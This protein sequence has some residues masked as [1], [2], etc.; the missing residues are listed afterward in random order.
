MNLSTAQPS[1]QLTQI[2]E[3]YNQGYYLQAWR[4]ATT[5]A[6]L[7][8][9]D[10]TDALLLAG[11]MANNLGASRL[12][13][14][15]HLKAYR[16]D[17]TNGEAAYYK[18]RV[19]FDRRGPLAAWQFLRK[20][21]E[22]IDAAP[23][24]QADWLAYH[25]VVLGILR[26]FD[27]AEEWLAKA[28]K[29][30]PTNPWVWI[31]RSHLFELEDKYEASLCA[32]QRSLELRPDFRPGV[33]AV[34]SALVLLGRDA[35]ALALLKEAATKVESCWL[36][37]QLAQ[38]Q[39]EL[40]Q[41]EDA[42]QSFE[43]FAELAPLLDESTAKWLHA[44]RADVAYLC[45]D[46]EA[47]LTLAKL[48]ES[49]FHKI[50]TERMEAADI[51]A[52]RVVLPVGFV[53]QHHVTC[54]PATLT[55]LSQYWQMPADHLSV[56]EAICYDGTPARSE[57]DWA[58]KQGWFVREFCVTWENTVKL[59][60]RGV[61]FTLTTVETGSAHL[62]S[63]IG[64]DSRRGTIL[65]RDPYNRELG[66]FA[67]Q[68][69]LE[70]YRSSGPRGMAMVPL[71]R[72]ELL[73][74]LELQDAELYDE[75]Y[76]VQ[77][78]L[79]A[80]NRE[81]AVELVKAMARHSETH[82]LTYKAELSV[83]E[84]DADEVRVLACLDKL[85]E[86]FPTDGNWRLHKLSVLRRL[87]RRNDRV[88]MLQEICADK[89]SHP[90]FWQM[91]A[92]ELSDDGREES[93][94][95]KLL[96]RAMRLGSTDAH[97]YYL[98]ANLLWSQRRFAEAKELYRFAAC[99]K[100]TDDYYVR[101][102]FSAAQYF[103]EQAEAIR[104]LRSRFQRFGKQSGYPARTLSWGYEQSGQ[105][106]KA[107]EA[108]KEGLAL[109]PDDAELI[110][111]AAD[112]FA[113][114]GDFDAA[115]KWMQQAQTKARRLDWL[116]E[117]AAIAAYR[118]DVKASLALWQQV[119]E[120]E[121]LNFIATRNLAQAL[122]D[123]NG[124]AA[125]L[126]FLRA[127]VAQFPHNL[128]LHRLLVEWLRETPSEAEQALRAMIE[129]DPVDAWARR[130]LALTLAQQQRY[131]TALTEAYL[132]QKLE[133]NQPGAYIVLGKVYADAGRLEE[134]KTAYRHALKLSVDSDYALANLMA[135]SHSST[136]RRAVLQFVKEELMQQ[137]TFGDGLLAYREQAGGT[138][139]AEELR[140]LL[141]SALQARP[142]LWHA[143][144]ALILQLVDMQQYDEAFT[145]AKQATEFFPLA[146]RIWFDLSLVHQGR[147]DRQG[148]IAAL[149]QALQISPGWGKAVRQLA[150]ALMNSGQLEQAQTTLEQ[151]IAQAPLEATTYGYLADVLWRL[152]EK[153]Q[154][155]ER[156][157]HALTLYPGYDWGWGC[158]RHWS[159][160]LNRFDD[161]IAFVR[162]NAE[163]RPAEARAW[164][165]IAE[166]LSQ[167][168]DLSER[169]RALEQANAIQPHLI[170][171][172]VLRARLLAEAQR[173]DEAR[174]ACAPAT[175]N[176]DL[177]LRL[178]NAAALV[179]AESGNLE[180]ALQQM[181]ALVAEEPNNY[182]GWS[183]LADWTRS[184]ET[185]KKDYLEAAT[186]LVRISPH[187]VVSLGYLGEARNL[188][189]DRNGAKEA[190]KRA[191]TLEPDYD[192][193]GF[194]LFDL[195]LED[196]EFAAAQATLALLQQHVGSDWVTLRALELA[197]KQKDAELALQ[198]F[199]AL[200][201]A[202]G[203]KRNLLDFALKALDEADLSQ[204]ADATL[205]RALEL[206]NSISVV[207]EVYADR[208]V[209]RGDWK[210][211]RDRLESVAQKGIVW[212]KASTQF[213]VK[214]IDLKRSSDARKYIEQHAAA[215]RTDDETWGMVGY[216]LYTLA[217]HNEVV[218]WLAD[219][220][221]RSDLRPWMMWNYALALRHL[222]RE[223][224]A[225]VASQHIIQRCSDQASD[226]HRVLVAFDEAVNGAT[227]SAAEILRSVAY[228]TLDEW[229]GF[230]YLVTTELVDYQ[231][232]ADNSFMAG[233]QCIKQLGAMAKDRGF[234]WQSYLLVRVTKKAVRSVG[235]YSRN[236]A[237]QAWSFFVAE[238]FLPTK[239]Q[240]S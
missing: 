82:R 107:L 143:W 168:E 230:I 126:V 160:E 5:L 159:K 179:E 170:E 222:N 58:E 12:G 47:A 31:E 101:A 30:D 119:A 199:R 19:V 33:Q 164:L 78:A 229:E 134:A 2:Q 221:S 65:V 167:P 116:H 43:R 75:L 24:V 133:P 50:V 191:I 32:A 149:Q 154:A 233:Y 48:S 60:E 3:L 180:R 158:L 120:A 174:A 202:T 214:L 208:C 62:Q 123:A 157:K 97:N 218:N 26:D 84:Y 83:A 63:V 90:Q 113:R 231:R 115:D 52:R 79:Y 137:V 178:R 150:D 195:Q 204:R 110:L 23:T 226:S 234:V 76:Q 209:A 127:R 224:E 238:C 61:P 64:Y 172:H 42:R 112:V 122:A 211:C 162:A 227:E 106:P 140:D 201:C 86:I 46:Y 223:D 108:L 151:A 103:H 128:S 109:R 173:F 232:A 105:E 16:L 29:C 118:G 228:R 220:R 175:F 34:A 66:E 27:A 155:I 71:A 182:E 69:M 198:Y 98:L 51:T 104:F 161:A 142:D 59:I 4:L 185:R 102:Y 186:N 36:M 9:W 54:A 87:A 207:G 184:D 95:L 91:Y 72:K 146:P 205:E 188:N 153:E 176:G 156:V 141:Q 37:A 39:T 197:A 206:E 10:G 17:P 130:E 8:Q 215:L 237:L 239:S 67:A 225:H 70:R 138:L 166:T 22:T 169:L 77:Q 121:P 14:K 192:F 1:V 200:C 181:R 144:S 193:A 189:G 190:Y 240:T 148:E 100:D 129:V 236:L 194:N 38:L 89:K 235:Q 152:G 21:G 99:L 212:Q 56:V 94:A 203:Q 145:L 15:L 96:Q 131:E 177:P 117:A 74:H 7:E 41:H 35:E 20:T 125:A 44:Q 219:W 111:Y 171:A 13:R 139:E 53:R 165:L 49:P 85:L 28:E 6:P 210:Q 135:I 80:H 183:R 73:A 55:M 57:R 216:V 93:K 92:G 81:R 213:L 196:S 163:K 147:L 136:E 45:G 68:E 132:A 217:R 114:H 11:R 18:A 187:Y 88:A 25:A 124:E 40:G